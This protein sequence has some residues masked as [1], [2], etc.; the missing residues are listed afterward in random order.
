MTEDP[1][2]L[3]LDSKGG[4]VA[5]TKDDLQ[6]LRGMFVSSDVFELTLKANIDSKENEIKCFISRGNRNLLAIVAISKVNFF[7][8]A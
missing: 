2:N 8:M 5:L 1:I 4:D 3:F 6:E 7:N